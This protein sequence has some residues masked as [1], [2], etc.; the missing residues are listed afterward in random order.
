MLATA[1]S[2]IVTGHV[3]YRFDSAEVRIDLTGEY[4]GEEC[5]RVI[6]LYKQP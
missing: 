5:L 4:G 6:E 2:D 3:D 1:G